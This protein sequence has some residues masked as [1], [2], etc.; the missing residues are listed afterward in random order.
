MK[1]LKRHK[2]PTLS[3]VP[4]IDCAFLLVIFF[5]VS[6]T[7][8]PIQGLPAEPSP[9]MPQISPSMPTIHGPMTRNPSTILVIV[10]DDPAPGETE[11]TIAVRV[12]S[13]E[14]LIQTG[15]MFNWL[16]NTS[17]D[18][19]SIAII[20]A[21]NEVFQEQIVRIMDI[22]KQT[23]IDKIGFVR[24]ANTAVRVIDR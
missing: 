17:E 12:G 7:F 22:V 11:G 18:V 13:G 6:T 23:G 10:I 20:Q 15:K 9:P 8:A 3:M 24:T 16:I 4:M 1:Y 2:S 19:K 21:G 14:D 5:T